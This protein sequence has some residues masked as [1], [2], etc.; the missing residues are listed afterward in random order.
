MPEPIEIDCRLERLALARPFRIA[1]GEIQAIEV[2]R[3]TLRQ[4][5]FVGRGEGRPYA[6]FGDDP[7]RAL[8]DALRGGAAIQA[9]ADR[10]ALRELLPAAAARNALDC[11]LWDLEAKKK[12]SSVWALAGLP[13]PRLVDSVWTFS[14][15]EPAAMAEAA[16]FAP[17]DARLK[18]K[19]GGDGLEANLARLQAIMAARPSAKIM[20]DAN[21]GLTLK[22]LTAIGAQARR[23]NVLVVEQPLPTADEADLQ[24]MAWPFALAADESC[25]ICADLPRLARL[26]DGVNIKLDKTGGLTEALDLLAGARRRGLFVMVGCMV[27]SSLA[28]APAQLLAAAADLAD[29]DG[30]TWL[31]QDY[32][33]GLAREGAAFAPPAPA[34]WG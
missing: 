6:R 16:R 14:L 12:G 4:G 32:A 10:M 11:A 22:E 31:A 3:V 7:Q 15:A 25:R 2:I 18:V 28:L 9:G 21:E 17:K 19:L 23:L 20:I 26:Y 34:L 1:R 13:A 29:L 33:P 24:P 8:Q 5:R 27:S 30:A